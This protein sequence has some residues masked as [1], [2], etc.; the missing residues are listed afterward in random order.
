M[1]NGAQHTK[2]SRTITKSIR[3]TCNITGERVRDATSTDAVQYC[4]YKLRVVVI[5]R[6][7]DI[8]IRYSIWQRNFAGIQVLLD[9]TA[10]VSGYTV[11]S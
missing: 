5:S 9:T 1:C 8:S 3:I 4:Q 7:P 2:N 6:Y 10:G 11:N